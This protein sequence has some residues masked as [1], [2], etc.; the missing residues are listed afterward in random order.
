M[1]IV[2]V[3]RQARLLLSAVIHKEWLALKMQWNYDKIVI[4]NSN[5][6]HTFF[7]FSKTTK[8]KQ[9]KYT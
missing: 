8:S 4:A 5:N 7:F 6:A 3:L 9:E 2:V 1:Q